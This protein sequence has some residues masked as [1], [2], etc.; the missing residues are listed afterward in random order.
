MKPNPDYL[1]IILLIS[2]FLLLTYAGYLSFKSI[3]WDV[4]K[5]LESSPIAIPTLQP[6][7]INNATESAI[8]K[9]AR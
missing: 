5:R 6:K 9:K 2:F 4:L 8:P 1:S 3:D 7:P